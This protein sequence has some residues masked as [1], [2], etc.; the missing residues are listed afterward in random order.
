MLLVAMAG[1]TTY[2]YYGC[3]FFG[4]IELSGIPLV[5]VD[6]FHP[7]HKQWTQL[8]HSNSAIEAVNNGARALFAALYMLVRAFYFPYVVFTQVLPDAWA[9]YSLP[10]AERASASTF[11]LLF[12]P[13]FGVLFSLLQWYW[14]SLIARQVA[15]LLAPDHKPKHQ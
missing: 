13:T 4:V 15:K 8:A 2:S 9:V 5:V 1:Q 6:L 3:C 11:A 12:I 7:K 14:A 10:A